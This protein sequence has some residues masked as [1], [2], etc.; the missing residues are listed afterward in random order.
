MCQIIGIR[1]KVDQV[2]KIMEYHSENIINTL[3]KKG[4]DYFSVVALNSE[5]KHVYSA[6]DKDAFL[7]ALDDDIQKE[8]AKNFLS[9]NEIALVF[10]S[11]QAPEMELDAAPEEQPY[12]LD[13]SVIAVHGTIHNDSE[14]AA[15]FGFDI[16]VDTEIFKHLF[17][18]E[19]A[20]EGTFTAIEV[21]ESLEF[22][23]RDNGLGYWQ[24][25]INTPGGEYLGDVVAT[26]EIEFDFLEE[27]LTKIELEPENKK[28]L[29]AAFSGGMDIAFSTAEALSTGEYKN[30]ILNYFDWGSNAS[31]DE[32]KTLQN[33]KDLYKKLYDTDIII[34]YIK[35]NNYFKEY[36]DIN[37]AHFK[38]NDPEAIGDIKETEKPIAYVPYRNTQFAMLLASIAEA[39]ELIDIDIIFGL[40]L[41]EGMVFMDNAEPWLKAV[42]NVIKYGGSDFTTTGTYNVIAPFFERTKTN[43]LKEFKDKHGADVFKK[44]LDTSFSCYYPKKGEPCGKCGSC[45][46]REKALQRI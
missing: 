44:I 36:F 14:L 41:S 34:N 31:S 23:I 35:C 2:Q 7:E 3:S 38:L 29:F 37:Q 26:T 42:N 40:N 1:T 45:I 39:D 30:A 33:F 25:T 13:N 6:K 32:I 24:S 8:I 43:M 15:E 17:I 28:T 10:F 21:T 12:L 19:D 20:I 22:I 18:K 27:H 11:R 4:G 9:G 16:K 46:L 5:G